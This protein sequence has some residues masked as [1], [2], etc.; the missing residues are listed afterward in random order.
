MT[1]EEIAKALG[2]KPSGNGWICHCPAHDDKKASLSIT[3]ENGKILFK[4][5]ANCT[6]EAVLNALKSKGLWHTTKNKPKI[7][8]T[9]DY[10]NIKGKLLYQ[11]VKYDN[12]DFKQRGP[13]DKGGWIWNLKGI[14][15][16]LYHLPDLFK[17]V[18]AGRT[19]YICEGEKDVD[20]LRA[21]FLDATTNSGGAG[22]WKK[23]YGYILKDAIVILLPDN[24]EPGRKHAE[25]IAKSLYGKAKSVKIVK[26]TGI[27]P[28][29]DISDW[30]HSG[31]TTEQ[32]K[33]LVLNTLE[34]T[35]PTESED[36]SDEKDRDKKIRVKTIV[37]GLIHLVK[38]ENRIKYLLKKNEELVIKDFVMNDGKKYKPRSTYAFSLLKLDIL[39]ESREVDGKELLNR[40]IEFTKKYLELPHEQAYLIFSLWIFHTYLIE[41]FDNTPYLV[42]SGT[43]RTGKSRSG[44]LISELAYKCERLTSPTEATMFRTSD[45]FHTSLVIDEIKLWGKTGNEAVATLLNSRYQ[46]GIMIPRINLSKDGEDQIEYFD[47]FGPTVICSTETLPETLEDR[48]ITFFMHENLNKKVEEKIDR[49]EAAKLRNA[50]TMFRVKY[51]DEVLP[52]NEPIARRRLGEITLPLLETLMLLDPERKDDLKD[53]TLYLEQRQAA[54]EGDSIDADIVK[55]LKE[56]EPALFENNKFPTQAVV[57]EINREIPEKKRF[58]SKFISTRIKRLGFEKDRLNNGIR[59]FRCNDYIL[60]RLI[61]RY[62]KNDAY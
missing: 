44:K 30:L 45:F 28:K 2:G 21:E 38:C 22:K 50:L 12:K 24:D 33:A 3:E 11:V 61:E 59:G 17:A 4:C 36:K 60:K 6:Q 49:K 46:R 43:K 41:K 31:G 16:V 10:V 15:R 7:V 58:K 20:N 32:L 5:Q 62:L 18:K 14:E 39:D 13:D 40:V 34:W 8:A 56:L 37:A 9:Y 57:D 48:S 29:G 42:F 53:F 26:L 35:P 23:E 47:C 27:P 55:I 52:E 25:R 54:E 1:A 19:I 51:I